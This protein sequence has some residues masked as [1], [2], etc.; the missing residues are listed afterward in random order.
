MQC[1]E[2]RMSYRVN[3]LLFACIVAFYCVSASEQSN[4][5]G[6]QDTVESGD[7]EVIDE[8]NVISSRLGARD[9][10][11]AEFSG[12][13]LRVIPLAG[14]LQ[15]KMAGRVSSNGHPGALTQVRIRGAE[16]DHVKVILDGTAM[17]DLNTGFDFASM[18]SWDIERVTVS[19]GPTSDVWGSAAISGV[20]TLSTR[21]LKTARQFA[22]S[23]GNFNSRDIYAKQSFVNDDAYISL[24][25]NSERSEGFNVASTG[26]EDDGFDRQATNIHL[27]RTG[28][29]WRWMGNIRT[30]KLQSDYDPIPRDGEGFRTRTQRRIAGS[31]FSRQFNPVW[32]S[33]WRIGFLQNEIT[34]FNPNS[35]SSANK[36]SRIGISWQNRFETHSAVD[37]A[38][39]IQ[40][41]LNDYRQSG[42]QTPFGDPNQTQHLSATSISGEVL[43]NLGRW[44]WSNALRREHNTDFNAATAWRTAFSYGNDRWQ[45][46]LSTTQGYKNPTFLER[47]GYSPDSFLG[48]PDLDPEISRQIDLS[49]KRIYPVASIRTS[50]FSANLKREILGF[51][52]DNATG[53]FTARNSF[54]KSRRLGAEIISEG[55]AETLRWYTSYSYVKSTEGQEEEVLRPEHQVASGVEIAFFD[56][57][58]ANIDVRYIGSQKSFDFSVFPVRTV[59]LDGVPLLST[60]VAIQANR[61]TEMFFLTDNLLDRKYQTVYGYRTGLRSLKIGV[62]FNWD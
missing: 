14:L 53:H 49:F 15:R 57:I 61:F 26:T 30:S 18:S 47:F 51:V 50:I 35:P 42:T 13:E 12:T 58:R 36:T 39:V 59:E 3:A 19:A 43:I 4:E 8:L 11:V 52:Y 55:G 31:T 34:N 33:D 24:A 40:H 6:T 20:V 17:N 21:P 7:A 44:E 9:V 38:F 16:A 48:N 2:V 60:R 32:R 29:D 1:T 28:T 46:A 54:S 22:M 56:R 37:Y 27:G 62:T 25:L 23:A 10:S 41:E 5:Q 45:M